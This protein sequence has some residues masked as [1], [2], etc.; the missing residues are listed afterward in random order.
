MKRTGEKI[1][2]KENEEVRL[3]GENKL[4][5]GTKEIEALFEEADGLW[6]NLQWKDRKEQIEKYRKECKKKGK[7]YE[8]SRR[9]KS[10]LKLHVSYD[11]WKEGDKRH[12]LVNKDI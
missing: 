6:I 5:E 8:K 11:G 10:E 7:K 2:A 3:L 12:I 1:E 9:V 4:K